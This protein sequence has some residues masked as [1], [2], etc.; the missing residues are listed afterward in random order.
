MDNFQK[1]F[2]DAVFQYYITFCLLMQYL[3]AQENWNMF[4]TILFHGKIIMFLLQLLSMNTEVKIN[5]HWKA[6]KA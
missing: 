1:P 5:G 3:I 6:N 4:T 2:A